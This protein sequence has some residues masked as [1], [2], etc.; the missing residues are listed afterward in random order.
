[1]QRFIALERL[2]SV[3]LAQTILATAAIGLMTA[4][5]IVTDEYL[6]RARLLI[7][8]A[9]RLG[10]SPEQAE[11]VVQE[12]H[13]RLWHELQAGV[14]VLD[15]AAWTGR[16]VYRQAMD[17]HRLR[18]RLGMVQG[19]LLSGS[20]PDPYE[21]VEAAVVWRAVDRLPERERAAVYLRYQAD[22]TYRQIA[23][24]LNVADSAARS[25]ASRGIGRLRAR[26]SKEGD[27]Q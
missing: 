21:A 9:M 18:R 6:R 22:F 25:Y 15:A 8:L 12:A 20:S 27:V 23:E 13:L 2:S 19:H 17:Q 24:V 1:M 11:D 26:L 7:G 10:L 5:Q 16:V 3:D 14:Q 4:D